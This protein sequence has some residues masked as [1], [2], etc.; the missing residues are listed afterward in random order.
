VLIATQLHP[1]YVLLVFF[2]GYLT[3][4]LVE[5]A[6]LLARYASRRRLT[7]RSSGNAVRTDEDSHG[8]EDAQDFL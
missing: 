4:G 7:S 3:L 5:S 2:S 6:V 8:S 1:A